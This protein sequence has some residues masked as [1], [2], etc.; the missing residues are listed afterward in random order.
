M[1]ERYLMA[2]D[3][4]T[5]AGRCFLIDTEGKRAFSAYR[6]W[7]MLED[8][9][10]GPFARAFDPQFYWQCLAESAREVMARAGIRPDQ[11]LAVS[12]TSQR[13]GAVFL[14]RDGHELYAG[15]N[16][17]ARALGE[18]FM[19]MDQFGQRAYESSG[20]Y[21][22]FLF[23]PARLQW[24]QNNAPEI[25]QR[26]AHIL[27]INDWILFRLCGEYACE[28]TNAAETAV[29]NLS[30][31]AWD[32]SLIDDI[33]LPREVFPPILPGGHVL[34]RVSARAAQDMGL[35]EGTPVVVGAADTQ[36]GVL[37]AGA[38]A[39]GDIAAVAGTT[40]PVQMVLNDVMIDPQGRLWS[41]AFI[42]PRTW[43][44][45]SN[46]G[47]TGSIYRW[48]RD[49]FCHAECV[50]A[51]ETDQD[52]FV[53]MSVEAAQSPVGSSGIQA[54][55]GTNIFDAK[56]IMPITS[57]L[58]MQVHTLLGDTRA[59]HHLL[60]AQLEGMAYAVRANV[61]QIAGVAQRKPARMHVTGGSSQSTLW[62]DILASVL[63]LPVV[64]PAYSEGTSVGAAI[65]A[66]V[67]A[68]VYGSFREGMEALVRVKRVAEPD[69]NLVEQYN[70]LFEKWMQV[71]E[72]LAQIPVGF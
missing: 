34:G 27:M 22:N 47:A 8:A 49:T 4:G 39:D 37:G 32:W 14:D 60:R 18:G 28:P 1:P 20:H 70:A 29:Y 11:V 51:R 50:E 33:G 58:I 5:G 40:T 53:I 61:A 13:E 45:E 23:V 59:R 71:R 21:L 64:V 65:C 2:L 66:G 10:V 7:G 56:N 63:N 46:A 54:F 6:E 24:H 16:Q 67:G 68:G 52:P 30:T 17:D 62:V 35:K 31:G 15:P 26:I 42:P 44:L 25:Y 72:V 55:L 69:V 41:G 12:S 19:L 9:A 43:V 36:C 48:M 3:A 38:I 57:A